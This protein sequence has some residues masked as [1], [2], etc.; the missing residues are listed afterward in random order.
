M[1]A[2][3]LWGN[4]AQEN[5]DNI[6]CDEEVSDSTFRKLGTQLNWKTLSPKVGCVGR[7]FPYHMVFPAKQ[8]FPIS[9]QI[10]SF[11]FFFRQPHLLIPFC[12][13]HRNSNNH[14]HIH[15]YQEK[16]F[17]IN[18]NTFLLVV[19]YLH[20]HNLLRSREPI[21]PSH[22]QSKKRKKQFIFYS[23][24]NTA[25]PKKHHPAWASARR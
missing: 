13:P 16:M 2:P 9:C 25:P 4:S 17:F 14:P 18:K 21:P 23:L 19:T 24:E 11:S 12:F 15:F 3:S 1:A 7:G 5:V 6:L 10:L 22:V 20:S 8:F